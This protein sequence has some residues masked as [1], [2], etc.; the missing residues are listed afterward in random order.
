M[1]TAI[2]LRITPRERDL[3]GF[4]VRRSLPDARR[5]TVGP[6]IFFDQ[7]GPARFEPGQGIDVRAH[8]HIGLATVTY[9]FD[10][11]IRHRDSLGYDQ[12][13]T[14]GAVNW[15][16]AG[17]GVV[18]SERTPPGLKASGS[19]LHGIQVWVALPRDAEECEPSF[20]H[21]PAEAIPQL[22]RDGAIVRVV[23]GSA[24]GATSP[25]RTAS[26]TLYAEL[27]LIAG[28]TV[29]IES[30]AREKAVYV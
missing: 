7:M 5:R 17:R 6:F 21:H 15:M 12:E 1:S 2:D 22:E 20:V 18:H 25:V 3:G 14:P 28:A 24:Y 19:S 10:G 8:P 16:T 13:I 4:S 23:L 26:E 27:R 11:R 30:D 9:L 29:G